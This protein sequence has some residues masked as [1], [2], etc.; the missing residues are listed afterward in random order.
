MTKVSYEVW[1][2]QYYADYPRVI[3]DKFP[4][5][6]VMISEAG[7]EGLVLVKSVRTA[8]K[9]KELFENDEIRNSC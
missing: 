2:T 1:A 6:V 4:Y 3:R 9:I 5:E 7:S 8:E